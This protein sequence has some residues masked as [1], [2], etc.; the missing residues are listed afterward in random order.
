MRGLR[1]AGAKMASRSPAIPD[2]LRFARELR[3]AAAR[4]RLVPRLVSDSPEE[5]GLGPLTVRVDRR[6]DAA[7]VRYARLPVAVR[8][9]CDPE[10][11]F[12]GCRRAFTQLVE[13]SV[14]PGELSTVLAHA[15]RQLVA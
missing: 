7:V 4:R 1:A 14:A 5:W 8:L 2:R 9:T 3:D 13:R 15:Y 10:A 11:I 12:A 6:R